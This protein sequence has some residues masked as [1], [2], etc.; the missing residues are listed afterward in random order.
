VPVDDDFFGAP[1]PAV[2]VKFDSVI[3]LDLPF[4]LHSETLTYFV[5][6]CLGQDPYSAPVVLPQA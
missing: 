5:P 1:D 4:Y 6:L 3:P 2:L